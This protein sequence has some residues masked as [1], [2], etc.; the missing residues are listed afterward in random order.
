MIRITLCLVTAAAL[1][2]GALAGPTLT[3]EDRPWG[4]LAIAPLETAPYP[5]PSRA[6]GFASGSTHY[7]AETHYADSSVGFLVP[8]GHTPSESVDLVVH[9]HGHGNHISRVI[10]DYLLGEQLASSEVNAIMLVPQ[11]PRDANDS[12]FGRLDEPGGFEA[13]IRECLACLHESGVTS[14]ETLGRIIIMG[15]SGGYYTLGQIIAGGDL[16]DHIAECWLWDA[17][18]AQQAHFIDFAARPG[19]HLRSICTGHLAEENSDILCGLQDRG[20]PA[21]FLHDSLV[22]DE[23]LRTEKVIILRTTTVAH[24]DV[25]RRPPNLERWLRTSSLA[26][27]D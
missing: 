22:T 10:A 7:P 12:R 14:T 3:F 9:F 6:E 16:A 18:Y 13:F 5:H 26:Q 27:G 11:G 1:A 17:A 20:I 4:R 8:R 2:A 23:Q 19:T 15:H 24:N 21:L 25:I